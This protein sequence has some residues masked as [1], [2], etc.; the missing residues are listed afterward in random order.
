MFKNISTIPFVK[1][2][3]LKYPTKPGI[4]HLSIIFLSLLFVYWQVHSFKFLI[5]WDDQWFVLNRYTEGGL[6]WRN[7]YSI[8][9]SFHYGQYSPVNQIYYTLL[10]YFFGYNPVYY[11][12]AGVI[13][14]LLNSFLIYYLVKKICFLI[15][16]SSNLKN[17]QIAFITA[18]L[19]A[20]SPFNQEPVAW[21]AASKV[22]IY[23]FFYIISVIFYCNYIRSSRPFYY[24]LTLLFFLI[25]FGAK[26]Q[27]VS[28]PFCLILIDYLNN[29]DLKNKMIWYEKL[30]FFI[31]S[32][33][34][35]IVT[36]QS[37]GVEVIEDT[38]F[39]PMLQRIVLSC[40]TLSEYFTKSLVPVNLSYLYPFPFRVDDV[41]PLW[42]WI[43]PAAIIGIIYCYYPFVR[44][45]W[46]IAGLAFFIIHIGLVINIFS[47][48][49]FSVI[50]DRYA[51]LATIGLYFILGY[52]FINGMYNSR[53][54]RLILCAGFIYFSC[55]LIYSYIHC[56]VWLNTSTL[57][58]KLKG[59]M[60]NRSD[61]KMW[62]K[63]N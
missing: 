35:G 19:F 63:E 44:K 7:I 29:R 1:H 45:K 10:Y 3:L 18:L 11:H 34:F 51:Y 49:R 36:I 12:I 4:F 54:K 31:L 41:M 42:L 52:L 33:L 8:L 25:S 28:L 32:L 38:H 13:I 9:K 17:S 53:H 59:T 62:K 6:N 61:F 58:D 60:I 56:G 55:F 14:H 20:I 47:L 27:A 22:T 2:V 5:G 23:A 40:F 43:Y 16:S 30:P 37:Q 24:Y 15:S 39:Y 48:A 46:I 50:A 57:K 21:V 26:E